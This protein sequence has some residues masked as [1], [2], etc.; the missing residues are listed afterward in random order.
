VSSSVVPGEQTS[1]DGRRCVMAWSIK[2]LVVYMFFVAVPSFV[3]AAAKSK[4]PKQF[5]IYW[6]VIVYVYSPDGWTS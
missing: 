6:A 4:T 3:V 5:G 1:Y 2:I